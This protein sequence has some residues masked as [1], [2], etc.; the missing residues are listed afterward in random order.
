MGIKSPLWKLFFKK[1][2]LR[3]YHDWSWSQWRMIL[4][5]L[6]FVL[7][8]MDIGYLS[9]NRNWYK[10]KIKLN[11]RICRNRICGNICDSSRLDLLNSILFRNSFLGMYLLKEKIFSRRCS[12][13][14]WHLKRSRQTF[15]RF[16]RELSNASNRL[17]VDLRQNFRVF[18]CRNFF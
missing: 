2:N 17:I 15:E 10:K 18:G 9:M 14:L 8:T 7:T 3:R 1:V 4:V 6:G 16:A 5:A 11:N 13:F 12:S